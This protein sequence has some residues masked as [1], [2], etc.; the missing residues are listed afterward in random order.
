VGERGKKETRTRENT[1]WD[2][3]KG[4]VMPWVVDVRAAKYPMAIASIP[5]PKPPEKEPRV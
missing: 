3:H 5:V 4:I 1:W 2:C